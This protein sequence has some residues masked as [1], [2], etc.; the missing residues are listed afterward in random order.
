MTDNIFD[1]LM[2]L[3]Q[4][5][6]PINWAL[7]QE[8]AGSIA[9]AREPIDPDLADE[10][11]ALTDAAVLHVASVTGLTPD[12][13]EVHP[14]DR[15]GWAEANLRA[16][17]YL[18]EPIATK[19]SDAPAGPLDP[20]MKPLGPAILGMQAGSMVGFMSQRVLG[21]FDIGMPTM[22]RPGVFYVVP[23]IETFAKDHQIDPPQARLWV[24]LHEVAHSAEFAVGWVRPHFLRLVEEYFAG[25]EFDPSSIAERLESMERPEDLEQ[26]MQQPGGVAGL[27]AGPEQRDVL[28]RIQAFMALMEGYADYVMHQAAP[29]LIPAAPQ[30]AEAIVRRRAEPTQGEQVLQQLMGL[31]LKRQQYRLGLAF[32]EEVARRWGEDE[33]GRIWEG[34]ERLPSLGELEDPVGWAARL[35]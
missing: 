3:L 33:L 17:R 24:A 5:P 19:M 18:V 6:G 23:N 31:E 4:S 11:S 30:I 20:I 26:L 8:I 16:F 25:L 22:D 12:T 27:L 1:R 2:E 13:T 14:V 34:P 28:D 15:A 21:Q 10:Y 35:L 32:C 9:G 29:N 7:G